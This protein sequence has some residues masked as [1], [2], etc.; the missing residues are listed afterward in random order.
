MY[1]DTLLIVRKLIFI[2]RDKI[3]YPPFFVKAVFDNV[4]DSYVA[5]RWVE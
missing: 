3:T 4:V 5:E 1:Y 2:Q